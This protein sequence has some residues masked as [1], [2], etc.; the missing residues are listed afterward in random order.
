MKPIGSRFP[1]ISIL[2]SGW[3]C[4][5]L[6]TTS[7]F[8]DNFFEEEFKFI[9][10]GKLP[11][12]KGIATDWQSRPAIHIY[13]RRVFKGHADFINKGLGTKI[14]FEEFKELSR[15]SKVRKYL[16]F[17]IYDLRESNLVIKNE[18]INYALR[19]QDYQYD[20]KPIFMTKEIIK[21]IH[22]IQAEE[23]NFQKPLI[24]LNHQ[25]N[26]SLSVSQIGEYLKLAGYPYLTI[27]TLLEKVGGNQLEVL[28]SGVAV[29]KLVF[30]EKEEDLS[31][32]SEG[33][34]PIL[35]FL[36]LQLPPVAGII[37]LKPQT[38]LS[39]VN[40]LA[41]NRGTFNMYVLNL[42]ILPGAKSLI[43]KYVYIDDRDNEV[44]ISEVS[45]KFVAAYR[46][47][48]PPRK[49]T[50]ERYHSQYSMVIPLKKSFRN[51]MKVSTIGAKAS[52]YFRLLENFP[53]LVRPGFALNFKPYQEVISRPEIE[54]EIQML[55]QQS[56]LITL[57]ERRKRLSKI[58]ELIH[59]SSV[60]QIT[61]HSIRSI[62]N[63][64]YKGRKIRLRSSTNCEDIP[65]FNGAGLY[66]SRGFKENQD[67]RILQTQ[68]LEVYASFW[69]DYAFEEREYYG[70][71]HTN[72][73]MAILIHESFRKE[74][75]NGV[76][77]TIPSQGQT[78]EI[79]V[80]SQSGKESI[81]NPTGQFIPESFYV[82]TRTLIPG[83][84]LSKST[85]EP[86]FLGHIE[87]LE[88]LKTLSKS[89]VKIHS[90][91]LKD[92]PESERNLYGV[93]IEFKIMKSEDGPVFRIKQARLL[94]YD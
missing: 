44:S 80:N 71:S 90:I 72:T 53:D 21:L 15:K 84:I 81:A 93:D 65:G 4:F 61:I 24:I 77:L 46:L 85:K 11:G 88:L 64:Y 10:Y 9:S 51:L 17:Y 8:P 63:K 36:P 83:K 62:L 31:S 47:K 6:L 87:Y 29:G 56:K 54:S 27:T 94:K 35:N 70:I 2:Y 50:V 3:F 48:N 45:E 25:K 74:L 14:R 19:L 13:N 68:I 22:L 66:V 12:W 39:H 69:S 57:A 42:D 33:D 92:V 49:I 76:A 75:A 5:I 20:D 89:I 40:L 37:T 16:P 67:D 34:I 7:V 91:F 73:G 58:R 79:L 23:P 78:P 28:N 1:L 38:I 59:T 55:I 52:N 43:G 41:K 30:I 82:N 18:K 86:V 32:V 26:N 60:S